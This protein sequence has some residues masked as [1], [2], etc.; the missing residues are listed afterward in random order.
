YRAARVLIIAETAFMLGAWGLAQYPYIIPVD[1]TI[2]NSAN[3]ANV[4]TAVLIA[5][6]C[7][8][9]IVIPSLYYLFSVFKLPSP[10]PGLQRHANEQKEPIERREHSN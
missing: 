2:D 7:G 5:L 8:M 6:V 9:I 4:I 10:A 1:Y 3:A